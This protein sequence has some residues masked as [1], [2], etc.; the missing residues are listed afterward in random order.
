MEG[1]GIATLDDL[2]D[3]LAA[4]DRERARIAV[5]ASRLAQSGAWGIDGAV[6]MASW[7]TH[8]ARMASAD[9]HRLLREGRFLS[10]YEA[11]ADAVASG[12]ISGAQAQAIRNG[13]TASTAEVFDD[14][15]HAVVAAVEPLDVAATVIC[16]AAWRERAEAIVDMP[17]PAAPQ[18]SLQSSRLDDGSTV[19]RFVCD[20]VM[21]AAFATALGTARTWD[22]ADDGRATSQRNGDALFDIVSFFNAN[23]ES[24]GTPRHRPHL[25]LHLEMKLASQPAQAQPENVHTENVHTETVPAVCSVTDDGQ[26]LPS[27]ATDAFACDCV[28]HR[29]LRS[30]SAVLDYGRATRTVPS[31]LFRAVACRDGGCR[32]PTCT[33]KVAWCEAHHIR[34]W[35]QHGATKLDNL[36]LLCSRHHHLVHRDGWQ[37]ELDPSGETR[38]VTPDGRV[39]TTHPRGRPTIRSPIAA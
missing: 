17:E 36:L 29:V 7:L 31:N 23:H 25:E 12:R 26:L 24:D 9:T 27:W 16:C 5:A 33:R 13:V 1:A 21:A 22:G 11:V 34:W 39:L 6:S 30:G 2:V 20:P 19:G 8:H 14:H 28:I 32:F 4:H 38:F 37:I 18:R 35:R 3:A 15:Q 10:R